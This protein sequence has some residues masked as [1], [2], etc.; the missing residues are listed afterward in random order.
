[1][2]KYK[3][4]LFIGGREKNLIYSSPLFLCEKNTNKNAAAVADL[5]KAAS[6]DIK[7]EARAVGEYYLRFKTGAHNAAISRMGIYSARKRLLF[8]KKKSNFH[9]K[10]PENLFL[11]TL[12]QNFLC[13]VNY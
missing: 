1:V 12:T 3:K 8:I 5:K 10:P 2:Q 6:C 13:E 7:E 11:Q 9:I 4:P